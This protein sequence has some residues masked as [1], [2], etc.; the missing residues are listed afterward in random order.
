RLKAR[1]LSAERDLRRM[2]RSGWRRLGQGHG[3]AAEHVPLEPFP[4]PG[5]AEGHEASGLAVEQGVARPP[6]EKL[7]QSHPKQRYQDHAGA[8][9]VEGAPELPCS[10]RESTRSL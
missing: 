8:D 6:F 3:L 7:A 1:G 2:T 9:P 10:L 4:K 5:N